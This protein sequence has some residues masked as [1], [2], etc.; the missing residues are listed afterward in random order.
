MKKKYFQF[1]LDELIQMMNDTVDMMMQEDFTRN[2]K[3]F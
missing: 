1:S 2:Y 3:Q